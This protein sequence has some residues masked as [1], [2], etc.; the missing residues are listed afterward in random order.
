MGPA[1]QQTHLIASSTAFIIRQGDADLRRSAHAGTKLHA[2]WCSARGDGAQV[3]GLGVVGCPHPGYPAELLLDLVVQREGIKLGVTQQ[4]AGHSNA[5]R[6]R[7]PVG[8]L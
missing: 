8:E 5:E 2:R 6:C 7:H 1:G 4:H 3:C